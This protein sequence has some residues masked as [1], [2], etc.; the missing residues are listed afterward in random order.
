[1]FR[2]NFSRAAPLALRSRGIPIPD[3]RQPCSAFFAAEVGRTVFV[4]CGSGLSKARQKKLSFALRP[5]YLKAVTDP[6]RSRRHR[7]R[8][9]RAVS[10]RPDDTKP[11]RARRMARATSPSRSSGART[12]V[13]VRSTTLRV[14]SPVC[15]MNALVNR[16]LTVASRHSSRQEDLIEHADSMKYRYPKY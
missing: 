7:A 15:A 3:T 10:I 16:H 6:G 13:R 5:R 9:S 4:P 14:K 11:K 2:C 8:L 12:F 1:L